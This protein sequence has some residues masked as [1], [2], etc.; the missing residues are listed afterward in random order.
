MPEEDHEQHDI[1]HAATEIFGD[2]YAELEAR[3]TLALGPDSDRLAIVTAISKAAW[4]GIL[5]GVAMTT[6]AINRQA[7]AQ[8]DDDPDADVVRLDP[9]LNVDPEPDPW[10]EQ[11]GTV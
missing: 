9:Q 11:Y 7:D 4:R 1:G 2:I 10:A 5:R 6:Y 8:E 3:L